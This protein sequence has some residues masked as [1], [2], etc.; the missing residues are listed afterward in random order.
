MSNCHTLC[1]T[2]YYMDT[3]LT[4]PLTG[5]VFLIRDTDASAT[6]A[7][8]TGEGIEV[9]GNPDVYVRT[10]PQFGIDDAHELSVRSLTRATREKGRVFVITT[11]IMTIE[12]QN[13][14]LKTI[15][16]PTAGTRFFFILPAPE[17]L[18]PTVRSRAQIVDRLCKPGLHNGCASQACT[19]AAAF[20]AATPAE[21]LDLI[22]PLLEKGDDP[23]TGLGAGKRDL[24]AIITFLSLIEQELASKPLETAQEGIKAIYQARK[25]I[26]DKGALLK[27]LLESVALLV[28]RI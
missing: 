1:Y 4:S 18:L 13:A 24:G 14:L 15:E 2:Q 7:Y 25:Y 21:R 17:T 8:L 9:R 10:Y 6:L 5:N 12:A 26:G 22:K 11:A 28:P 3:H 19:T 20:L 16:E 27:P 23:S